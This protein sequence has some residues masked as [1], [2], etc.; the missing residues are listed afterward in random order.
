M[1]ILT[2]LGAGGPPLHAV[3]LTRELRQR[4]YRTVLVT[5][6]CAEQ[7][8][9]MSYL[10]DE[11]DPLC[12]IG[13]MSRAISPLADLKALIKLVCLM[14]TMRPAIV[15]THTA[16]A[17]VLGRLAAR[18]AGVPVVVHT[19]H[20]NVLSGYFPRYATWLISWIER[21]CAHASDAICVLAEQQAEELSSRFR[22]AHRS[23]LHVIPLGMDL[24]PYRDQVAPPPYGEQFTVG[25]LGRLVAVKDI[26]LLLRIVEATIAKCSN[27]RFLIA[28]DGPERGL[29]A[30]AM[31]RFG[32]DR[33][34]WLGWCNDVKSTIAQSNILIQTS[35][36]EGTP[37]ALIQGMAAARTFISTPAGGVRNMV[38]GS[39]VERTNGAAWYANGVLADP[40]PEAF[41]TA[42]EAAARWPES[43]QAMGARAR[44]FA[45]C[46]FGLERLLDDMDLLYRDI[47][48]R[49]GYR[50]RSDFQTAEPVTAR[51]VSIL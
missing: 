45:V 4:G 47:L 21:L 39:P 38:C 51:P 33:V 14:R 30:E 9:D 32:A 44:E 1:R 46:S 43:I 27:V 24:T 28:G 18:I 11:S 36:N 41:C 48:N 2:R 35:R 20:G 29:V 25:W 13:E 49:K 50:Q 15:H 8:G 6:K 12:W 17:G 3:L 31:N 7:D 23:K 5:G 34:K 22:I 42:I 10:I 40:S 19:F 37:V 26:P 16:K